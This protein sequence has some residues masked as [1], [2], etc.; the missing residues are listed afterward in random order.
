MYLCLHV[1]GSWRSFG[2][3]PGL[4][5]VDARRLQEGAL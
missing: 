4:G 5:A 3:T 2:G 1:A